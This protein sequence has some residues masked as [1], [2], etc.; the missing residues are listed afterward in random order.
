MRPTFG[1]TSRGDEAVLAYA[2]KKYWN[3]QYFFNLEFYFNIMLILIITLNIF[4]GPNFVLIS[5]DWH[6]SAIVRVMYARIA[7]SLFSSASKFFYC[8]FSNVT[9]SPRLKKLTRK[10]LRWLSARYKNKKATVFVTAGGSN[11]CH[12]RFE[13]QLSVWGRDGGVFV[14]VGF[15]R[16]G[17][18]D[19]DI[20]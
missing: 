6:H 16:D 7:C 1:N 8:F 20:N 9:S 19:Y 13:A 3:V 5:R 14:S 18:L 10:N 2:E 4:K 17:R 15:D 11:V 12:F